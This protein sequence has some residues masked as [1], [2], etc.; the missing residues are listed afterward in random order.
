MN[1]LESFSKIARIS[2]KTQ[3]RTFSAGVAQLYDS[4][5]S[6]VF[7]S[8]AKNESITSRLMS[9]LHKHTLKDN[10]ILNKNTAGWSHLELTKDHIRIEYDDATQ[11]YKDSAKLFFTSDE[12]LLEKGIP[13]CF[14][15]TKIENNISVG[16][17]ATIFLDR[18]EVADFLRDN[19]TQLNVL[20]KC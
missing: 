16:A 11:D 3:A 8:I 10:V 19:P 7:P 9:G 13:L 18:T 12:D 6:K 14:K 2:S 17:G 4:V 20:K 5:P 1:A 15:P